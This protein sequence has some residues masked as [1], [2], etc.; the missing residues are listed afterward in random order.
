MIKAHTSLEDKD[1]NETC[2]VEQSQIILD[3][4]IELE[5]LSDFEAYRYSVWVKERIT[6]CNHNL[7][8]ATNSFTFT[9]EANSSQL[10][11]EIQANDN[12]KLYIFYLS[13]ND[14]SRNYLKPL[15]YK[16]ES[17]SY[18][19]SQKNNLNFSESIKKLQ[20]QPAKRVRQ[21]RQ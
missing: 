4:Q 2:T 18:S 12:W 10:D 9:N 15:I 6:L 17:S 5:D 1:G 19:L 13:K 3:S 8:S 20:V 14:L 21:N 11:E 16:K 7:G